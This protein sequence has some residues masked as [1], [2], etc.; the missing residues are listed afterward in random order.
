MKI[1]INIE[2]E[3]VEELSLVAQKLG[4][5]IT[6][7]DLKIPPVIKDEKPKANKK[8]KPT[9]VV[10]GKTAPITEQATNPF[11][12]PAQM[13]MN[14]F[15]APVETQQAP[16]QQAQPGFKEGAIKKANDL[17]GQLKAANI[18]T[19]VVAGAIN[20]LLKSLGKPPSKISELDDATLIKFMPAF[21]Q[22]V[23]GL[24]QPQ[25]SASFI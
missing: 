4:S 1:T 19:P 20:D 3:S 9:E 14:D 18:A 8:E 23:A 11:E 16:V 22:T 7:G 2:V 17:V 5:N 15:R 25:Q 21:E 6:A 13:P 24:L 10:E 12:K